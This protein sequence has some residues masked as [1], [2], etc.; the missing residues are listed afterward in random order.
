MNT[1]SKLAL[2]V[3]ALLAIAS[4]FGRIAA[5]GSNVA[6]NGCAQGPAATD[7]WIAMQ[8]E[9]AYLYNPNLNTDPIDIEVSD[10]QVRLSGTVGSDINRDL[11]EEIAKGVDGVETVE[12][13]LQV[14]QEAAARVMPEPE[15]DL[16]QTVKD[17]TTTAEVKTRLIAN[18]NIAARNI[19]VDTENNIV[20]LS[21]EVRSDGERQLAEL[22]ARNT[23]GVQSVFNELEIR[24]SS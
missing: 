24:R 16:L 12:N 3:L 7:L 5:A 9:A 4:L 6:D 1:R 20:R 23:W 21:G 11:A 19:D 13:A 8:L 10:H 15:T 2:G 22:I 14:Q 18:A 17:A